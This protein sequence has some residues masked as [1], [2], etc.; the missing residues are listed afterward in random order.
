MNSRFFSMDLRPSTS[1]L[2]IALLAELTGVRIVLT[3][4]PAAA[5]VP[6]QPPTVD[7]NLNDLEHFA[8]CVQPGDG[9]GVVI[10]DDEKDICGANTLIPCNSSEAC[11][12]GGG[13][14]YFANGADIILAIFA[15]D[16]ASDTFFAGIR[17]AAGR[18]IGDADGGGTA[19]DDCGPPGNITDQAGIGT[20]EPYLIYIDTTGDGTPEFRVEVSGNALKLNGVPVPV[21]NGSY[22]TSGPNLELAVKGLGLPHVVSFKALT[23]FVFDG[24][25]EDQTEWVTCT[26]VTSVGGNGES[27]PSGYLLYPS[28]PNPARSA[29]SFRYAL[30][31][32]SNAHLAIY[33][34]SGRLVRVLVDASAQPAGEYT[35]LWDGRDTQG[36]MVASGT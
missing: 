15:Y 13:L 14:I 12:S 24:L 22:A 18:A 25:S 4:T 36:G 31:V 34:V 9:C 29:A 2:R 35:A 28:S 5:S 17:V 33:D 21:G 1:L 23:G 10:T 11:P 20:G 16:L 27:V 30:P 3:A 19:N 6:C 8:N 32:P 7:G 26:D